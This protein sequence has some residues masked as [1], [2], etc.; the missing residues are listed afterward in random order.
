[1]LRKYQSAIAGFSYV[2]VELSDALN[3]EV[4]TKLSDLARLNEKLSIVL[5]VQPS[6]HLDSTLSLAYTN[7]TSNLGITE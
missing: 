7:S 3:D 5:G 4:Y 1:V 6:S 2:T